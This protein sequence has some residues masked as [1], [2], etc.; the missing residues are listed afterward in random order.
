MEKRI[1]ADFLSHFDQ[2][3]SQVSSLEE[4]IS[5]ID[6]SIEHHQLVSKQ[7]AQS[8]IQNH[9]KPLDEKVTGHVSSIAKEMSS[10]IVAAHARSIANLKESF[11]TRLD[12]INRKIDLI[13]KGREQNNDLFDES[14]MDEE[15]VTIVGGKRKKVQTP[16]LLG[17]K[18]RRNLKS[19]SD[20]TNQVGSINFVKNWFAKN[21]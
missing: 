13:E 15:N 19:T 11:E 9:T 7:Q 14:S 17:N 21:R 3:K 8:S 6:G 12:S 4:S 10:N 18:K 2:V 16:S 5:R 1:K 20:S